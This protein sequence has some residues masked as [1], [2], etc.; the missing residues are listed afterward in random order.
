MIFIAI[1]KWHCLFFFTLLQ[2]SDSNSENVDVGSQLDVPKNL[3]ILYG[4]W[5]TMLTVRTSLKQVLFIQQ[6]LTVMSQEL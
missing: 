4:R 3:P 5:L 6:T 1:R 2:L